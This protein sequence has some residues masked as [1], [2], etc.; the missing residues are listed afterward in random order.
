[1]RRLSH[2]SY[3]KLNSACGTWAEQKRK[4]EKNSIAD[5]MSA[6]DWPDGLV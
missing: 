2:A 1:M 5:R 4:Y 3:I 6:G